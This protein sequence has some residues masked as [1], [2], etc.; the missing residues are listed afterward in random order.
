M[1]K[2]FFL[3]SL[4]I[5]MF[6][7]CQKGNQEGL[8]P[9]EDMAFEKSTE[10]IEEELFVEGD[11]EKVFFT[12]ASG[13]NVQTAVLSDA[14]LSTSHATFSG[15][16]SPPK[17][18]EP[19][20]SISQDKKVIKTAH[21]GFE[22]DSANYTAQRI[23]SICREFGAYVSKEKTD[24]SSYRITTEIT[25]RTPTQHFDAILEKLT[26]GVKKLDYQNVDAKDV[27]EQFV[28]IKARL[29]AKKEV[30]K[31]Y[32][33][34]LGKAKTIEEILSIEERIRRIQEEIEAKTG[35]LRYLQDQV[36]YS[37]IHL[38]YYQNKETKVVVAKGPGFFGKSL[39][40]I[41]KGWDGMLGFVV[42]ILHI[43]PLVLI[44]ILG[45]FAIRRKFSKV[46]K[47]G[48]KPL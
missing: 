5:A 31:R 14:S 1:K 2:Q 35:R 38:E 44:L 39:T 18:Q 40:A 11:N 24:N 17:K 32:I 22:T 33:E 26:T 7:G 30:E 28:D 13:T 36:S 16:A 12:N 19:V 20:P 43:W 8:V 29:K 15:N 47:S 6:F 10:E 41:K 27:T 23:N 34:L 9:V 4:L 48:Q 42:G 45:G 46:Q 21:V 25:L 37:T 3:F